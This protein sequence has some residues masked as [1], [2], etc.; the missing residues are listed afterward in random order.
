MALVCL[1]AALLFVACG[2]VA[3]AASA[4]FE[5]RGTA[6]GWAIGTMVAMYALN[7]L[8][9][10]WEP[11]AG[12]ARLTLFAYFDPA[13]TLQRG[14]AQLGDMTVL[15]LVALAGWA[16]AVRQLRSRDIAA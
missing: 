11:V 2:A 13:P 3:M 15:A 1:N 10:L 14:V 12:G 8:L 5:A 4:Y 9:R 16:F 7:F 6:L